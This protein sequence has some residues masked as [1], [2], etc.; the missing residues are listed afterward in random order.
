MNNYIISLT[1]SLFLANKRTTRSQA[2]RFGNLPDPVS[3]SGGIVSPLKIN[4]Q[5]MKVKEVEKQKKGKWVA[6][7]DR[8]SGNKY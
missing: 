2:S 3:Q 6:S 1:F 8:Q 7:I 5:T 4:L